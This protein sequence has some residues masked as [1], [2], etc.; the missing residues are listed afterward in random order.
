MTMAAA[1]VDMAVDD[2]AVDGR[3]QTLLRWCYQRKQGRGYCMLILLTVTIEL[4]AGNYSQSSAN[5]HL[6]NICMYDNTLKIKDS[7]YHLV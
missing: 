7:Y 2:M 5:E 1:V 4:P 3:R 6:P